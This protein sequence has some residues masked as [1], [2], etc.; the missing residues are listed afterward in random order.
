MKTLWKLFIG[1]LAP[2][3]VLISCEQEAIDPLSGIYTPPEVYDFSVLSSQSRVKEGNLYIFSVNLSDDASNSL[4]LKLAAADYILPASDF[5][6]SATVAKNTYLIGGNGST[7]NGQ[8]ITDGT[9][10]IALQDSTYSLNGILYLKC[11]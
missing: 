8:E 5:T 3:F 10:S 9:I 4:N 2:V 6:P 11:N 7:C 1:L